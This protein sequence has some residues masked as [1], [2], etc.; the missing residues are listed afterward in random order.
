MYVVEI[1]PGLW[2]GDKNSAFDV[3]FLKNKNIQVVINCTMDVGFCDS[4]Q[5]KQKIRVSI[6]DNLNSE[7]IHKMYVN[8]D[9]IVSK[10]YEN[11]PNYNILIHCKAG[12]QRSGTIMVAYL[13]KYADMSIDEAIRCVI[14]KKSDTFKTGCHFQPALE[15]FDRALSTRRV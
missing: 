10:V 1:I 11:I 12:I 15:M 3:D 8:L 13:M 7:E 6:K 14:S 5:L 9:L 2:L 4:D